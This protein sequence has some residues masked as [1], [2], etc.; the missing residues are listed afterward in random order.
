MTSGRELSAKRQTLEWRLIWEVELWKIGIWFEDC[1]RREGKMEADKKIEKFSP[2]LFGSNCAVV[3]L[4][5]AG[6]VVFGV[7]PE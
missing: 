2:E 6:S 7:S 1:H 4:C 5:K 3:G